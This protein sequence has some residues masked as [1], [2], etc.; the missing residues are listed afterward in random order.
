MTRF[1][2]FVTNHPILWTLAVVLLV[3]LAALELRNRAR[4]TINLSIF[5][6][7]RQL[8]SENTLLIDLRPG[9]DFDKGHIRGARHLTPSQVD[10]SAKEISKFK[11]GSVLLY[12]QSGITSGEVADRLLKAGFAKVYSLKGGIS[13]W[14]Q[15]QLPVERGKSR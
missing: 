6:F 15:D 3:A 2:E 1:L 13:A 12:C 7:T 10:P 9:A 5:D 11:D 4:G 8:N 14:M